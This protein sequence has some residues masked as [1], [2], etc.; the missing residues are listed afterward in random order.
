MTYDGDVRLV[1]TDD[2]GDIVITDGQPDMDQGLE[3]AVYLSLF[4][5]R[6]WWGAALG[7]APASDLETVFERNLD[8]RA[9]LDAEEYARQAL[10]WMVAEGVAKSVTVAATIPRTDV[11]GLTVDIVEPG[12]TGRLLRYHINWSAQ[13]ARVGG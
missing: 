12:G 13:R 3:T 4:T 5:G 11:L 8:N 1:A 10:A 7:A 6:P 9:R 2:G